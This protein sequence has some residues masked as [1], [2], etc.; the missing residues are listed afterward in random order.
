MVLLALVSAAAGAEPAAGAKPAVSRS[1]VEALIDKAGKESPAWLDSTPLV[2]PATLDL[3]W[4]VPVNR[5]WVADKDISAYFIKTID[6]NPSRHQEGCKLM[7]H[8]LTVNKDRKDARTR[9]MAMLGRIYGVYLHDYARGAYWYRKAAASGEISERDAADL[10]YYYW[11]LG[12]RE[13]ALAE[14]SGFKKLGPRAIHVLGAMGEVDKALAVARRLTPAEPAVYLDAGDA[15]RYNGRYAEAAT[16]YQKMLSVPVDPKRPGRFPR[17]FACASNRLE[18][19]KGLEKLDLKQ[20]PDGTYR[21][22]GI[23]YRAPVK[24]EVAV[25]AGRIESVKVV[26]TKE[27]WPL[28]TLQVVPAMIVEKQSVQGVDAVSGASYTTHAIVIG[29][30]NALSGAGKK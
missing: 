6:P 23:G 5:A 24:V 13:M 2:C 12:S 17:W 1:A 19:I 27:D 15:C 30:G 20:I 18:G 4:T 14:L 3:T 16:W 8:V 10:G 11:K 25:K 7:H 28:N 26:E 21:G 9:A 29:T 22:E